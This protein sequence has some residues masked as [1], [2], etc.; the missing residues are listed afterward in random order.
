MAIKIKFDSAGNPLPARLIL[1]T[2]SGN[3]IR[4]LPMNNIKFRE[5]INNGSEF[6]FNVYKKRCLARSGEVDES[7][8]RR[9][10]SGRS[11]TTGSEDLTS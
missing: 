7:F 4:E 10:N 11:G 5:G 9:A 1:A 2:R 6:S 3:R 8:W